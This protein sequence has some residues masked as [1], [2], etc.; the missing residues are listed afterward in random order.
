MACDFLIGL[1]VPLCRAYFPPAL[2]I[3]INGGAQM[4]IYF[5]IHKIVFPEGGNTIVEK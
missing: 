3:F 2:I 1:Y 4:V 5:Q